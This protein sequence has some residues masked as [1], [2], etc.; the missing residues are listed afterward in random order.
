[1]PR[2]DGTGPQG[3]GPRTGRGYGPC[4]WG[5]GFPHAPCCG[6]WHH[7]PYYHRPWTKGEE[8]EALEDAV[9]NLEEELKAVKER[10]AELKS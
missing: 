6:F 1:M 7:G 9:M 8:R 5:G 3:Y 2:G 4:G 10:L